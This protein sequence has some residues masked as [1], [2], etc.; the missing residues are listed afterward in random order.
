[1]LA[2]AVPSS[3]ILVTLMMEALGSSKT[4]VLTRGKRHNIPEDGILG[5]SYLANKNSH[6]FII[7]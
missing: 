1:M 7:N 3:R 4:S 5:S 6:I 2:I